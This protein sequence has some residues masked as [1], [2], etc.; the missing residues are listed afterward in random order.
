MRVH[1]KTSL[2]VVTILLALGLA[3][4]GGLN[5]PRTP[6]AEPA[7]PA[8]DAQP[9]PI[10]FRE[11]RF[12]IPTGTPTISQS[13]KGFMGIFLCDWPYTM[14]QT[15]IRGRFFP[16][17]NLKSIFLDTLKGQGYDVT[18]DP[19]RFFDEEEDEMRT[20]YAVGGEITDIKI[21][22]C[23]RSN[24]WGI[25]Q[26]YNGEGSVEIKWSVYDLLTRKTVY[27]TSTRGY[28]KL[29][30]PNYEGIQLLFEDA[31]GAAIYNLGADENFYKLVFTGV[32]PQELPQGY[33]DP[34]EEP[35]TKYDSDEKV[36][37]SV[38]PLFETPAQGRLESLHKIAVMIEAGGGHGSGFFLS[39]QGHILTNSHVVGNAQRVRVVTSGKQEK[40][41]AEVLRS[42]RMRDVA[43]LKLED[44]PAGL[45]IESLPIRT[46]KLSVGED[47]YAIGAP[48]LRRL[49][50]TVTKG[51]VSAHRKDRET[52]Q[53]LIQAD[54]DTHG[55][56]SGGPLLDGN[57][58]LVGLA[59]AGYVR[60]DVDISGLN[61]F[62]PIGDALEELD[63]DLGKEP[64][65]PLPVK[66]SP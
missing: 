31:V 1:V 16:D 10:G 29:R 36:S 26:G 27:K 23:K 19:G 50:D 32:E 39:D 65:G 66:L 35:I 24:I 59:V 9:A 28:G 33:T 8:G 11:I 44:L 3:A 48:S 52:R 5:V 49:Q 41:V 45:H 56:N 57:G 30:T 22:T 2:R 47:V 60:G 43:L 25:D 17:D 46:S 61:L 38:L 64:L 51:I 12:A 20:H 21:D 4:C 15:G 53:D 55:G 37:L 58:N 63:I 34:Y 7:M 40:L 62:I 42:D 6:L 54:V 14:T 18:G 13:P